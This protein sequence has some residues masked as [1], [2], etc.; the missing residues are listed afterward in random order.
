MKRIF[1]KTV[2]RNYTSVWALGKFKTKY[3][4]GKRFTF[5]PKHPSHCFLVD[6]KGSPLYPSSGDIARKLSAATIPDDLE[7]V[8]ARRA[9]SAGSRV[10]ICFGEVTPLMVPVCEVDVASWN[11]ALAE[12][13]ARWTCCDFVVLG[14]IFPAKRDKDGE[15]YFKDK[16]VMIT[17]DKVSRV[18][19]IGY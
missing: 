19:T 15:I 9:E 11:F 6:E 17:N 8:Y 18:Q 1:F 7:K 14:E 12:T 10:L 4:V 2:R 16:Q 5:D 13:K 3:K